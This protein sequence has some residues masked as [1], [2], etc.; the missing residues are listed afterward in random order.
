MDLIRRIE[1]DLPLEIELS[2]HSLTHVGAGNEIIRT[3]TLKAVTTEEDSKAV[4]NRLIESLT[5]TPT[6]F[7]Y[8]TAMDYKLVP[9]LYNTIGKDMITKIIT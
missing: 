1:A 7:K 2:P 5:C 4:L 3:H 8:S 6:N 9:F